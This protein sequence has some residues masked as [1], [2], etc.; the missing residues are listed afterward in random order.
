L[1]F[2]KGVPRDWVASGKE[3]KIDHAPTRW[4]RVNFKILAK[5]ADKQVV[6]TIELAQAGA[7]R[8]LHVKLRLPLQSPLSTVTVNGRPASIGGLHND[9]VMITTGNEKHFEVVGQMRSG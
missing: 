5:P 8:E 3:I 1:Y 7:P 4:G 2:A 9:T 6:A